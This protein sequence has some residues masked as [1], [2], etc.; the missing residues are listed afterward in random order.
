MKYQLEI[1]GEVLSVSDT[2]S[3]ALLSMA[4]IGPAFSRVWRVD[5]TG[6][7]VAMTHMKPR[8]LKVRS[9]NVDKNHVDK[10]KA[11]THS[12]GSAFKVGAIFPL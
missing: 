9:V 12:G 8:P 3:Q 2:L 7:R 1:K 4:K 5:D 10:S 6:F 11:K